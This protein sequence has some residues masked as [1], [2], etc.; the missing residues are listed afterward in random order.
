MPYEPE[1]GQLA[2]GAPW[3][4]HELPRF[5]E[6]LLHDILHELER[7]YWNVNQRSFE[8]AQWDDGFDVGIPGII[9]RPYRLPKQEEEDDPPDRPNFQ[10]DGVSIYWYK[11]ARRGLSCNRVIDKLSWIDWFDRCLAVLHDHEAK[12]FLERYGPIEGLTTEKKGA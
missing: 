4:P 5:A 10:F 6:A 12:K 7:V 9:Y 3:G 1:L 2:F 11:H 8:D